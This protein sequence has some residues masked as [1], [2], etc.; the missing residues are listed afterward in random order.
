MHAAIHDLQGSAFPQEW[1]EAI[2]SQE[3]YRNTLRKY[4]GIQ[5]TICSILEPPECLTWSAVWSLGI[6]WTKIAS[7]GSID[8]IAKTALCRCTSC[9]AM[10]VLTVHGPQ[11]ESVEGSRH[12]LQLWRRSLE[13]CT[14]GR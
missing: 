5:H 8:C 9:K 10:A 7:L 11:R 2:E 13:G 4:G 14:P 12:R 3:L 6:A 1:G